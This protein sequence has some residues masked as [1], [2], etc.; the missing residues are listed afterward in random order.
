MSAIRRLDGIEVG[1]FGGDDRCIR[2]ER[3]EALTQGL[4]GAGVGDVELAHHQPVRQN[5]LL[6]R[7]REPV[8][9]RCGVDRVDDGDDV[10][11]AVMVLEHRL[12][13]QGV[14]DGDRVGD[15]GGLH[16]DALV[17]RNLAAGAA[18]VQVL[19]GGL[20]VVAHRAA[21]A[22]VLQQQGALRGV[23]DQVVIDPD[24]AELV[25][26]HHRA[27]ETWRAQQRLEQGRLAAAEGAGEDIDRNEIG[28]GAHLY[29]RLPR[30]ILVSAAAALTGHVRRDHRRSSPAS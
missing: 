28:V 29:T 22:A 23:L 24:L 2:V 9:L 13:E 10:A 4:Q 5:Y 25:D 30:Y 19:Q 8:E 17:A 20:Q 14:G 18:R 16:H 27:V 15:A 11:Q 7:L 12:G 21:Q 3:R 6:D 26:E 1:H